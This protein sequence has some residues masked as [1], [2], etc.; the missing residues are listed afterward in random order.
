[1]IFRVFENGGV[2]FVL[3]SLFGGRGLFVCL[4]VLILLFGGFICFHFVG[5]R[6]LFVCLY[7]FILLSIFS[8]VCLGKEKGEGTK[9]KGG[10]EIKIIKKEIKKGK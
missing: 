9:R 4:F 2:W 6:D 7:L 3:I 10:G 5:W 8:F 1:M